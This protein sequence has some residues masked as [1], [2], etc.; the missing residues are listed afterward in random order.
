MV[1]VARNDNYGGDFNARFEVFARST[2][3]L[4]RKYG[5]RSEL[6][7]VEW[8][9]P[10]GRPRMREAIDWR[11]APDDPCRVRIIE[12]P[13]ALHSA[14]SNPARLQ[15]FE[16]VGKNVGIR[17]ARA[18][19][20]LATNPDVIWSDRL[21]A[22]LAN[23]SL[24]SRRFY[25]IDRRDVR[26]PLPSEAGA[27]EIERYCRRNVTRVHAA[28]GSYVPGEAWRDVRRQIYRFMMVAKAL[29]SGLLHTNGA[30]DFFLMHRD[31]W[32]QLRAYPELETQGGP[33]HI[34]SVLALEALRAGLRQRV[35]GRPMKLYHQDHERGD[36]R[37][38]PSSAVAAALERLRQGGSIVPRG[39]DAWGFAA[40]ALPEV[41]L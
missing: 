7:V 28:W 37:K 27:K 8:N 24:A 3:E 23:G 40:A 15:L 30:G 34:D 41:S 14:L 33:H 32:R 6:I 9:P 31:R 38:P 25:R 19:W 4:C 36:A 2:V 1:V 22:F 11:V 20:V 35:L 26:T 12:V 39:D 13:P 18:P 5:L 21:A 10:A 16:Y 17:R 29:P